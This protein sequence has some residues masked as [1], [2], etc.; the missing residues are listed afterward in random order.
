MSVSWYSNRLKV[1]TLSFCLLFFQAS[2]G[3]GR[4]QAAEAIAAERAKTLKKEVA[5]VVATKDTVVFQKDTKL[6]SAQRGQAELGL[7]SQWLTAAVV[8]ILVD[9][10]KIS[11]DDKVSK[12]LPVFSSYMKN[13]VTIRHC[14]AHFTGIQADNSKVGAL[15][16]KKKFEN[17]DE[18]AS[19]YAKREIQNNAGEAF[20]FNGM[21]PDIAARVVEV[22]TKK[23]FEMLAQ[24]KLFRPLGM[25][26]T[27]FSTLDGSP[28]SP[29]T[30]ARGTAGDYA[31]FLRMLLNGGTHY[32][33]RILSESSVAAMRQILTNAENKKY[34]PDAAKGW[35]YTLGAWAVGENDEAKAT[36]L[37]APSFE[38]TTA[39][40]DFCRGYAFVYLQQ[41]LSDEARIPA[42][43]QLKE[44]LDPLFPKACK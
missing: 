20:R 2:F 28:A 30:G 17:L 24:Q 13:Y 8:M 1:S 3:Q 35:E 36:A 44:A 18:V 27:T 37:A 11:L 25:R 42:G 23:K 29:S 14:L 5:L 40:I 38:G 32:G 26:Q 15:F 43:L 9:E 41:E 22:V 19:S 31:R 21:G 34:S 33:Q 10:G 12:Y 6:F 4:F 7:S 16:A 39:L